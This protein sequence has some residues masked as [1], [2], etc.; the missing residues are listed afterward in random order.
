M[1]EKRFL[2]VCVM[3]YKH[4]D[5]VE[6]VL[7]FWVQLI[8]ELNFDIYYYD[9]S[10]DNETEEI[11]KKYQEESDHIFYVRVPSD[12]S[13]DEKFLIPYDRDNMPYEYSYLWPIKD[14][15]V[16][17]VALIAAIYQRLLT[18]CDILMVTPNYYNDPFNDEKLPESGMSAAEFYRDYAWA[19]A[20]LQS[21]I[22][23]YNT[24]LRYFNK[25][26]I[27]DRYFFDGKCYFS[28]TAALF[29]CLASLKN[30]RISVIHTGK[31]TCT[32]LS[33]VTASGWRKGSTG[34]SV[35]GSYWPMIN[36]ALPDI[37]DEYKRA[38]I[39]KE[40]N[41]AVLFGSVDGLIAL[42]FHEPASKEY[43]KPMLSHWSDF[44]D[45]PEGV[46]EDIAG[47]SFDSAY[48]D[49]VNSFSDLL[50]KNDMKS[51]AIL[52]HRNTWIS[53]YTDFCQN[54][55]MKEVFDNACKLYDSAV[56]G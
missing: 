31:H 51:L 28:H 44:S 49:F 25:K 39:R 56:N 27:M 11:V 35:F 24:V 22:Y 4:P 40:T 48:L 12:M 23:N 17:D 20:D 47:G 42:N 3:T 50:E 9:S 16:P 37:Y 32:I 36:E 46:A 55:Q 21:A 19:A 10:P 52:C 26:E 18:G 5:V 8:K 34:I 29:H 53:Y 7:G 13:A 33:T 41:I 54:A 14:R 15:A 45:V 38:A 2:A 6:T 43:T 1:S 30:P